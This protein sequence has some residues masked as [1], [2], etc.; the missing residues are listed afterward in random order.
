LK[1]LVTGH[2]GYIGS[3]L[4][5]MLLERGHQVRGLDSFLFEGCTF[6]TDSPPAPSL[7]KDLRD[8]SV[9]DLRGY[10]AVA[11]L[12]AISNDP[13]GDLNPECTYDINRRD[14]PRRRA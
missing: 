5:P 3:V 13:L 11:H 4:V 10:D 14:W 7:R 6:G 1:V 2:H 12:G 9:A 8:V